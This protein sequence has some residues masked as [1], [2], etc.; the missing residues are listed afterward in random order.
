MTHLRFF[1]GVCLA[2]L[3]FMPI[4]PS[5]SFAA[6]SEDRLKL[7]GTG[8][9]VEFRVELAD[10]D[11]ERAQGLMHRESLP[12]FAGMLFAYEAARPVSFWMRNTLIPLDMLFFDSAGVLVK[13]HRNAIPLDE[14]PIF[15]GEAIQYILEINGGLAEELGIE[16]G[17]E[18]QHP[19]LKGDIIAWA[20]E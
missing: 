15:G 17:S 16:L 4:A 10:D 13:I 12:Q 3:V 9:L 7:R 14:T 1:Y 18:I 6:C 2:L 19:A 20:C 5:V 11:A 8:G